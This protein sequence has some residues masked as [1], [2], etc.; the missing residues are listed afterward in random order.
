MKEKM[1]SIKIKAIKLYARTSGILA[2]NRG[3]AVSYTHL[4]LDFYDLLEDISDPGRIAAELLRR[5][6]QIEIPEVL[7]PML[8]FGRIRDSYFAD[9]RGDYCPSGLILKREDT[10]YKEVY[11]NYLP[12]PGY[13]KNSLFLLHL[14]RPSQNGMV[15][16]SLAIPADK[17]KMELAKKELGILEFSECQWNQYGGCLLYTSAAGMS[18]CGEQ[19][20]NRVGTAICIPQR[21]RKCLLH[22]IRFYSDC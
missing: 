22:S 9:H 3:E 5:G 13:D 12:D 19:K 2:N 15:N 7:Y 20:K 8:D 16:V 10:V 11:Q 4:N 14:R 1:N 6:K 18:M 17:E 21:M